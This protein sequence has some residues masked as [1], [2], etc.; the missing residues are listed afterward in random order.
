MKSIQD[1]RRLFEIWTS[2]RQGK[3][4]LSYFPSRMWIEITNHCNL[5][6]PLCPNQTLPQEGKGFMSPE[7][8]KKIIDQMSNRVHDLNVFHRGEPL[9][10]P[11]VS[12]LIGYAQSRGIICRIHTNAT[13]LSESLSRRLLDSRLDV[14]SFSFDGYDALTYEKNRFPARFDQTLEKIE[15]F[16]IL[17]KNYKKTRPYTILQIM[18]VEAEDPRSKLKKFV[19]HLKSKGLNRVV[20]RRPHNWG[21]AIPL[22]CESSPDQGGGLA[23][24][25]F[26]WYALVVYWDG[27]V[28]PCPQDFFGRI[29]LG[30]LT[31]SPLEEIWNGPVLQ[32]F[33][34]QVTARGYKDLGPCAE[35][36]R[37][38]RKTFAGVPREYLK[39]FVRENL[40]RYRRLIG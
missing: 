18:A 27:R 26:P 31:K 30:D 33:R 11:S 37:P 22:N 36:D 1:L 21:G 24:C 5:K 7:L 6:C 12:E 40:F 4:R 29:V 15:Q 38:R 2:F 19:S 14:L 34:N 16:L 8:F 3:N 17:K 28:G 39:S 10:H 13:L 20:F 23:S 32:G 35:C 9:L 25:T